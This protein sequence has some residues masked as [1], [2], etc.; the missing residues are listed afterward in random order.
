MTT[1]EFAWIYDDTESGRYVTVT[2]KRGGVLSY[3]YHRKDAERRTDI[4]VGDVL[5]TQCGMSAVYVRVT[6]VERAP[7][8]NRIRVARGVVLDKHWM[9]SRERGEIVDFDECVVAHMHPHDDEEARARIGAAHMLHH[10]YAVDL[11]S[12]PAFERMTVDELAALDPAPAPAPLPPP[13]KIVARRRP[14]AISGNKR[15]RSGTATTK[16]APPAKRNSRT[17]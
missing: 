15:K 16:W 6:R 12:E 1:F 7:K 3:R 2:P 9:S 13:P 8:T 17:N 5:L 10:R 11:E 4:N 14:S